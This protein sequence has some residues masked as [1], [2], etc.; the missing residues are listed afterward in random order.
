MSDSTPDLARVLDPATD[1]VTTI[2]AS[3]LTPDM[4]PVIISGPDGAIKHDRVWIDRGQLTLPPV[5]VRKGLLLPGPGGRQR[6]T[7][8]LALSRRHAAPR[9]RATADERLWFSRRRGGWF[10][11]AEGVDLPGRHRTLVEACR[12][13]VSWWLDDPPAPLAALARQGPALKGLLRG[14]YDDDPDAPILLWDLLEDR[15]VGVPQRFSLVLDLLRLG[16]WPWPVPV[17]RPRLPFALVAR[18]TVE[19][20]AG[21]EG[22]PPPGDPYWLAL[23]EEQAFEAQFYRHRPDRYVCPLGAHPR[24]DEQSFVFANNSFYAQPGRWARELADIRA[25]MAEAGLQELGF[26]YGPWDARLPGGVYALVVRGGGQELSALRAIVGAAVLKSSE[27]AAQAGS[28]GGT[29][30]YFHFFD[31]GR[32][33]TGG[34]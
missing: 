32:R 12:A 28:T 24:S 16:V 34:P 8:R 25:R 26:S 23:A 5:M 2:P 20:L 22:P 1:T 11:E 30:R 21:L 3:E 31:F 13:G 9:W 4:V 19:V 15:G 33:R 27:E 6:R 18:L 29:G 14:V 10:V 7:H 17:V